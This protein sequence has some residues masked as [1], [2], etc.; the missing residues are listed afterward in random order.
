MRDLALS[1]GGGSSLGA[2]LGWLAKDLVLS[3]TSEPWDPSILPIHTGD[4]VGLWP[5]SSSI[6]WP[7]LVIGIFLG[8]LLWPVIEFIYLVRQW[9]GLWLRLRTQ[10]LLRGSFGDTLRRK[11]G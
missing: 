4:S 7:S 1:A 10:Q 6:H 2:L 3:T 8:F 5:S 11:L 9:L